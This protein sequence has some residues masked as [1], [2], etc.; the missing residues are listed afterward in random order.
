MVQA[1]LMVSQTLAPGV[2]YVLHQ[3]GKTLPLVPAQE[4][5]EE[6][7]CLEKARHAYVVS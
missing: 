5:V 3:A 6:R 7:P 1:G 4:I 2:S